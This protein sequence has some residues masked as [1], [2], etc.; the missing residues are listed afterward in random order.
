MIQ[1]TKVFIYL[2]MFQDICSTETLEYINF[3]MAKFTM[4]KSWKKFHIALYSLKTKQFLS[5]GPRVFRPRLSL[6]ICPHPRF[7]CHWPCQ[8]APSGPRHEPLIIL[9]DFLHFASI[10]VKTYNTVY[11]AH[12]LE[13]TQSISMKWQ[14]CPFQLVSRRAFKN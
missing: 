2:N 9:C 6:N 11:K 13:S 5:P 1:E 7:T 3:P 8:N 10:F 4:A 12:V 14:Q